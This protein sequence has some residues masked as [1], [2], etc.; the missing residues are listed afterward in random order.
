LT[1]ESIPRFTLLHVDDNFSHRSSFLPGELAEAAGVSTDTLRHYERKG[2]LPRPPR[3]ANGYRHYPASALDRIKLVRSS[4]AIGFTLDELARILNER[5][6]GGRPCREVH[7]LA[8]KK[9]GDLD[10]QIRA[11]TELRRRLLSVVEEWDKRLSRSGT[12]VQARLLDSLSSN[13]ATTD[14]KSVDRRKSSLTKKQ[15]SGDR[16]I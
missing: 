6:R 14:T 7:G 5:D 11:L 13:G 1:L 2:V 3:S 9:L 4:L 10:E 15:K 8:V 12:R 16:Q